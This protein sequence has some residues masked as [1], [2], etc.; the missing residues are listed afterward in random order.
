MYV[1]NMLGT[2]LKLDNLSK[3]PVFMLRLPL[4]KSRFC[5]PVSTFQPRL[6]TLRVRAM[7][8]RKLLTNDMELRIHGDATAVAPC[9]YC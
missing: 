9:V 7:V 4:L 1:G 6:G 5:L 8:D 2:T 3:N